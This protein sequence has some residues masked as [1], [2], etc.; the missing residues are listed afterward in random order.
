MC[1]GQACAG[2]AWRSFHPDGQLRRRVSVVFHIVSCFRDPE[3]RSKR[4]L[5]RSSADRAR[6]LKNPTDL[7]AELRQGSRHRSRPSS[8]GASPQARVQRHVI[9]TCVFGGQR[10]LGRDR[11]QI[12]ETFVEALSRARYELQRTNRTYA[13]WGG[14]A[15]ARKR[16]KV[17]AAGARL[18][19]LKGETL[20]FRARTLN[21][22]NFLFFLSRR[23]RTR[24]RRRRPS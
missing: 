8:L 21:D 19:I 17:R 9:W 11:D 22:L 13:S 1:W 4:A 24:S 5:V 20:R 6:P 2:E 7:S 12:R 14:Q 18:R 15:K 10:A 3:P 23:S 16:A